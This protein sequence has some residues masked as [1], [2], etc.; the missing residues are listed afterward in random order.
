MQK[1]SSTGEALERAI[2]EDRAERFTVPDRNDAVLLSPEERDGR[3]R[4]DS[5]RTLEEV[6]S[7]TAPVDDVSNGSCERSCRA[8]CRVHEA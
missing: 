1:M 4:L 7:L 6:A 3:Q 8:G 5:L 2:L